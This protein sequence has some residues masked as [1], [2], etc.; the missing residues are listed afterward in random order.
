MLFNVFRPDL[1][2]AFFNLLFRNQ[3][4]AILDNILK[5]EILISA[6]LNDVLVLHKWKLFTILDHY[7]ILGKPI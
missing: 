2:L 1:N 3:L 5:Y 7:K 6:K 4:L